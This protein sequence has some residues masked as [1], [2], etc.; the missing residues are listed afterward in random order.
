[1]GFYIR[2]SFRA[3]PIRLNLS[4]SGIGTSVG[5]K[6]LRIG[7]S[8]K[9][10]SYVHAGRGGLYYRKNLTSKSNISSSG[11]K[12]SSSGLFALIGILLLI[13]VVIKIFEWIIQNPEVPIFIGIIALI[14]VFIFYY[15]KSKK[16]KL[17][18]KYKSLLD[19]G[20]VIANKTPDEKDII[21]IKKIRSDISIIPELL[22]KIKNIEKEVYAALL[23]KILDDKEITLDEKNTIETFESI[24]ELDQSF[25]QQS[26]KELF[27]LYYYD[28]IADHKITKEELSKITNIINGLELDKSAIDE[29]MKI[30]QEIL[31]AQN[32]V[33]PLNP[34][35]S[36][37]IKIQKSEIPYYSGT[38][39]ILSRKKIKNGSDDKY[40]YTIRREGNYVI[41]DKRILIV[42]DGSSTVNLKE[43][44]DVDVDLDKQM[45]IISKSNSSTPVFIQTE[46][47]IYTGK[48]IDLLTS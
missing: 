47:A 4:K 5:V 32:L 23:D 28:A 40:E 18:L 8:A 35:D 3:G 31:R 22:N 39:K 26:K 27:S 24:V 12:S 29:E 30:I 46:N 20:F 13:G 25:K 41:T 36:V 21:Q 15:S 19:Q 48:I 16:E 37:P 44:L 14:S 10:R 33:P 17:Y 34:I 45:I 1:M 11:Q 6:G 9:G 2:K 42:N 7:T 43:V 38:G